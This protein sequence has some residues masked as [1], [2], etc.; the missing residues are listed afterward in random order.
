MSTLPAGLLTCASTARS[1]FPL[2]WAVAL[3]IGPPRLQW[4][5]RA[6]FAPASRTPTEL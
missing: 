2:R 1:A 4:L 5:D 6:G 3:S